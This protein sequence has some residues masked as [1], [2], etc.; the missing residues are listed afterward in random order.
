LLSI[1]LQIDY[2]YDSTHFFD[3][4]AKRDLMQSAA[5]VVAS[6][7]S[8]DHLAAIVP[9]G[10]NTWTASFPDPATG[11]NQTVANLTVPA[12]TVILFVGSRALSGDGEAGNG[13]TG[14]FRAVG[15]KGWL[16]TVASGG[17]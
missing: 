17:N 1:S 2:R 6:A 3:T 9:A 7:L 10:S 11:A 15:C 5:N 4:P 8:N 16:Y 14:G 13:S 12:D